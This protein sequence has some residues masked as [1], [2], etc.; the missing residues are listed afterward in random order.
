MTPKKTTLILLLVLVAAPPARLAFAPRT[1]AGAVFDTAQLRSEVASFLRQELAAHLEA[2]PGLD[3]PPDRIYGALTTGEFSWGAFMRGLAAFAELTGERTL[4]G[5]DIANW[6][7][8]IGLVE[9]KA[10]GKAF[11]QLY[12][13]QAL[14]HFGADLKTNAVWRQLSD[15]QRI[16]WRKLLDPTSFYDPKTRRAVN[17]PEN[18]LGVAAR[19]A[20]ITHQLGLL[21]DRRV[22]DDLLDRAAIQFTDGNLYAD[23]APPTGRFDR[24]SNEYARFVWYAAE[25][26]GRQDILRAL[27]PSM[28]AQM[29]LWWDLLSPDGYGY[30][31]GRSLGVV[32]YLDT[33]EI[34]AFLGQHPEFRPA[35]L[36]DLASAYQQAWRWL[37]RDYN[38]DR[39]LLS[40]FA[41]GRGNYSY[42]TR[43]REWQQTG[44]F[45]SKIG[46]AH[47][48]L[49]DALEAERVAAIPSAPALADVSRFESFRRGPDRLAGVWVV[50]NGPLRFTLP[51]TTGTKPGISDYLPAPHGLPGFAAPVEQIYPAFAPHIEL[52]DG[53]VIVATDGADEIEPGTDGRSLRIFWRRWAVVGSKPGQLVDPQLT[54]EVTW[55]ID[56]AAISREEKLVASR[57]L[58]IRRWW[59]AIPTTASRSNLVERE[60]R[61]WDRFESADG[62][63]EVST[64][65]ADW[66]IAKSVTAAGDLAVGRGPRGGLPLHLM[67]ESRELRLEANRPVRWRLSLKLSGGEHTT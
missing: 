12:A 15:K 59:I 5:R 54:S 34:V 36:A 32:S 17:L 46:A 35:P 43:Q 51:I 27:R 38:N 19:I 47:K 24:Y 23:D 1:T 18:Y 48:A 60:G 44:A 14:R 52:D 65:S 22:L 56:G 42:I 11:S 37:R 7:G 13:A 58:S 45:F 9:Y 53:R 25:M 8:R 63:L 62:T 39:H 33:L 10:G 66:P 57:N 16:A 41:F 61:L 31:W 40:V 50:R 3:P 4:A 21:E 55:R 28:T 67:F 64:P 6:V 20:A 49:I 2:I 29:R 30:A 26:A